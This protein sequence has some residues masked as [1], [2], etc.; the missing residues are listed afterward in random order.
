MNSIKIDEVDSIPLEYVKN[1]WLIGKLED[2]L[3]AKIPTDFLIK[4][5]EQQIYSIFHRLP[6]YVQS[7]LDILMCM[8]CLAHYNLPHW[9]DHIDGPASLRKEC[10]CCMK[11]I[12]KIA[13]GKETLV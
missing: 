4:H 8:P 12:K 3:L 13:S 9:R 2:S 11:Q 1:P 7:D 10:E 5:F 6:K